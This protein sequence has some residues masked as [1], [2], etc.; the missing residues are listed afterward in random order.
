[1][2]SALPIWIGASAI[3]VVVVVVGGFNVDVQVAVGLKLGKTFFCR[4]P[5]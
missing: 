5:K 4:H 3:S 1:M 2:T